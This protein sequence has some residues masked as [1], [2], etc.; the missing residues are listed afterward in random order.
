MTKKSVMFLINGL[1]I[2]R[3]GSYSI[4]IDQAMPNLAHV[5]ETSYFTTAITQSLEYR[6]AYQQFFLGDTYAMEVEYINANVVNDQLPNN[7]VYQS[8][9]QS[10]SG[11]GK[12]HI[13]V[14]PTN[15][16]IADL[17]NKL[18]NGLTLPEKKEVYLH[19]LLSQLTVS[20]YKK[21]IEIVNYIKYHLNTHITV[22]F[23]IG[24]EY[25]SEN[26][27]KD[28][29][30]FAKKLLF[31]CSAER[32]I[33]TDKKLISLQESNIRPCSVP[34]FCATNSCFISNN[35]T[36]MFFNTRKENYDKFINAILVNAPEALKT[37]TYNLPIYSVIKLNS[38]HDFPAFADNVSYKSSLALS[39]EKAQKKALI[40]TDQKNVSLINLLANGLNN[41]NNPA[42]QFMMLNDTYY[43]DYNNIVNLIDNSPYDLIIF[44]YYMDNAQTVNDIKANLTKIDVV[45]GNVAKVCENKHSLFITSLYGMKKSLPL[46]PYN[47]EMVTIDYEMQIPIFFFDYSYPKGKYRLFPGETNDILSS[48]IRCIWD[49]SEVY[50][51]IRSKDLISN[52][53]SAFKK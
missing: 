38:K 19:L 7:P 2:E 26:L 13:F 27:T 47:T 45:L 44:D 41:V 49:N 43:N 4:A 28:E 21:L 16:Q 15:N 20:D 10:V 24:K 50:T 46:A 40:I 35:D 37:D 11:E 18:V 52:L 30:D 1:G 3:P 9:Q 8:F 53:M 14:E 29:M 23:I 36:I 51:L 31:F 33:D 12:L 17:I 48:A 39:L 42:I 25:F 22:G 6:G 34:G 32:W 5:K